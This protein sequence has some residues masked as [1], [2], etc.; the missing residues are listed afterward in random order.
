MELIDALRILPQIPMEID[1]IFGFTA[2]KDQRS[3]NII[4]TSSN[5]KY[6]LKMEYGQRR[7]DGPIL[8]VVYLYWSTKTLTTEELAGFFKDLSDYIKQENPSERNLQNWIYSYQ[9]VN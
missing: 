3:G 5:K 8:L 7:K 6:S 9:S 4:F 2:E 1:N